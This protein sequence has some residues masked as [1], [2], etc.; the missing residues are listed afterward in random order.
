MLECGALVLPAPRRR[1]GLERKASNFAEMAAR[2]RGWHSAC[3]GSLERTDALKGETP[4]SRRFSE[5]LSCGAALLTLLGAANV[6]AAD[7]VV[8]TSPTTTTAPIEPAA[9]LPN[10]YLLRSGMFT[11]GA[12]Y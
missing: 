4:M 2:R 3:D 5:C 6:C 1:L 7:T 10:G 12:A 8:V 9:A 11:L